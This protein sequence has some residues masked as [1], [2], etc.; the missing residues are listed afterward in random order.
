MNYKD[1]DKEDKKYKKGYGR[2]EFKKDV[3]EAVKP[4]FEKLKKKKGCRLCSGVPWIQER[5]E[6][7]LCNNVRRRS[8]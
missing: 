8:A 5:W 3:Q 7:Y 6:E 4:E 1:E 2:K